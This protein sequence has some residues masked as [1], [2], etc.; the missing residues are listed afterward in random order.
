MF[1]LETTQPQAWTAHSKSGF[2]KAIM[3][4][5]LRFEGYASYSSRIPVPS[6]ADLS[7]HI[8]LDNYQPSPYSTTPR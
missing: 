8:W 2:R 7:M 4:P 5:E 6:G 3:A 1:A